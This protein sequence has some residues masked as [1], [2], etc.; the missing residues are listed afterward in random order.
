MLSDMLEA[1]AAAG[2]EVHAV[3]EGHGPDDTATSWE[4]RGVQ[5]WREPHDTAAEF[6]AMLEPDVIVSHHHLGI[7]AIAL[8]KRIGVASAVV[9]HN[10]FHWSRAMINARPDL[11]VY[12]THWLRRKMPALGTAAIIIHPTLHADRYALDAPPMDGGV[13]L[14]NLDRKHKGP[15]IFWGL[16]RALP[17][18][19][20]L[21]VRGAYGNQDERPGLRNVE[22]ID[23][24]TDVRNLVYART[25][26]LV[27]PSRYE[28]YGRVAVEA[29][30]AGIPVVASP[31]AGLR[32]A[33][34]Y[35]GTFATRGNHAEWARIVSRYMSD[36]AE[37]LRASRRA[38]A[39]AADLD[40]MRHIEMSQW[41][42]A[43]A[44]AGRNASQARARRISPT[45]TA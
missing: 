12:N 23:T 24:V 6:T 17:D 7:Q 26:V 3:G 1:L 22:L 44:A 40:A 4:Y 14:M 16:A 15:N 30:A 29:C 32:E 19:K 31:T 35:A 39:R 41:V 2:H 27:V 33:L 20:F 38:L 18:T 42:S 8:A 34:G 36:D 43:V 45:A 13:T 5:C 11:L 10:D 9:L 25:R 28:S 21:G 37:W